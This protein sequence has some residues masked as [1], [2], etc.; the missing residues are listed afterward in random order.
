[1]ARGKKTDIET[2]AKVISSKL[3]DID[4]TLEEI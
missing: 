3:L 2:K 1:M 4:K